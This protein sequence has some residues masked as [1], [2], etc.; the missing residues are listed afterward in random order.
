[1]FDWKAWLDVVAIAAWG[2][3]LLKY[4]LTGTLYILVH[5][6]YFNLVLGAGIL[7]SAIAIVKGISIFR[8]G[9][10]PLPVQHIA[11]LPGR[12]TTYL[13]L[14]AAMLALAITPRVFTSYT[15]FQRGVT[16]GLTAGR[17][18]PKAFRISSNT[19]ER[20]LL[21]WIRTINTYP[22]PDAYRGQKMKIQGF[23][24]HPP[25]L[26]DNYVLLSKFVITCCAADAYPISLPVELP[27]SRSQYPVD[28]WFE[29]SGRAGVKE[30]QNKRQV[31][32][33][34]K[35]VNPIPTPQNPY[36]S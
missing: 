8:F 30:L 19:E 25:D 27:G 26:P 15:A 18:Q 29:I 1:M 31:V 5:P 35:S 12:T 20:S 3:V 11:L 36:A 24:V 7:L 23:A 14:F 33:I 22:E 16:E 2:I 10:P 28:R 6:S 13:L 21:E 34:A 9:A 17:A 32:V 4:W